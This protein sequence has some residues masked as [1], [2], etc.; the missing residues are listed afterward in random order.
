MSLYDRTYMRRSGFKVRRSLTVNLIILNSVIFVLQSVCLFYDVFPV[1]KYFYLS[2]Q[3]LASGYFWQLITF[4]FLHSDIIHILINCVVLYFFGRSMEDYL[5]RSRFLK[6]YLLSGVI[7][8]VLQILFGLAVPMYR[9]QAVVGASAG[10]FGLVAAF[11]ALFPEQPLTALIAFIIPV[12]M[13]AKYLLLIELL[14]TLYG[15]LFPTSPVAHAAHLGGIITGIV[16]VRWGTRFEKFFR[17]LPHR[18]ASIKKEKRITVPEVKTVKWEIDERAEDEDL[19]TEEFMRRE[20]D[21]IL[22]KIAAHGIQ[23]LTEKER[24]ILEAARQKMSKK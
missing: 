5:G 14:I 16:Y 6:L 21:P 17:S 1:R 4:Q 20:V 7:G 22:D 19:P 9:N 2:L 12:T 23:S 10:V 3:G 11:A 8:G 18:K 15:L 24:K 13:R